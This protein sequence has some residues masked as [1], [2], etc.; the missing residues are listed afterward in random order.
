MHSRRNTIQLV[1]FNKVSKTLFSNVMNKE[2]RFEAD[3]VASIDERSVVFH[4]FNLL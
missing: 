2:K 1:M 3:T 4:S